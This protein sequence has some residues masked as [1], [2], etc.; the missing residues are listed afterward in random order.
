[1]GK[2][3]TMLSG[4]Q[5]VGFIYSCR[6]KRRSAS[7]KGPVSVQKPIVTVGR[8]HEGHPGALVCLE[9]GRRIGFGFS[10]DMTFLLLPFQEVHRAGT[11]LHWH[12]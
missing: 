3:S 5:R 7:Q 8:S 4:L 2:V 10:S 9:A 12:L 1:M 6:F 11:P